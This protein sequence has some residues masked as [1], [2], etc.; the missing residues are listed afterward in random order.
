[1]ALDQELVVGEVRRRSARPATA[2]GDTCAAAVDDKAQDR[3]LRARGAPTPPGTRR[4]RRGLHPRRQQVAGRPPPAEAALGGE[5][6]ETTSSSETGIDAR[7]RPEP[8]AGQVQRQRQQ[9]AV[10]LDED[11]APAG[12]RTGPECAQRPR[13]SPAAA[14]RDRT[15][16]PTAVEDP[17]PAQRHRRHDRRR[18]APAARPARRRRGSRPAPQIASMLRVIRSSIPAA[19]N[20]RLSTNPASASPP[21]SSAP[22]LGAPARAGHEQE[23]RQHHD[24]DRHGSSTACAG[25][26]KPIRNWGTIWPSRRPSGACAIQLSRPGRVLGDRERDQRQAAHAHDRDA[27]LHGPP[28]AVD[29]EQPHRLGHDRDHRVVVGG[30]RERAGDHPRR[31]RRA[32]SGRAQRVREREQRRRAP[33]APAARTSAP[34]ASTR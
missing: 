15:R 4:S 6:N 8:K 11:R 22:R 9:V 30:E 33:A 7:R 3:E 34:P 28:P 2:A 24:R 19:T 5:V 10:V 27:D 21:A 17:D 20:S 14:G 16:Q 31:Q 13:A 23:H 1:M 29:D 26:S 25:P 32:A 18:R 12:R